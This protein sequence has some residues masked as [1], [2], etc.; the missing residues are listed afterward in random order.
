MTGPNFYNI[1]FAREVVL[2]GQSTTFITI[3][4]NDE[5]SGAISENEDIFVI[6]YPNSRTFNAYGIMS[7][8]G[9]TGAAGINVSRPSSQDNL[10]GL[11]FNN[12]ES[13]L[14]VKN[15]YEII[16][17][18]TG[19]TTVTQVNNV[20][21]SGFN[22]RINNDTFSNLSNKTLHFGNWEEPAVS[23]NWSLNGKP[24]NQFESIAYGDQAYAEFSGSFQ[25]IFDGTVL[26]VSPGLSGSGYVGRDNG[27]WCSIKHDPNLPNKSVTLRIDYAGIDNAHLKLNLIIFK[28][29]KDQINASLTPY[30]PLFVSGGA[31][32]ANNPVSYINPVYGAKSG[33]EAESISPSVDYQEV[34]FFGYKNTELRTSRTTYQNNYVSDK[35]IYDDRASYAVLKTNPKL[36]GNVKLTLDSVGNLW[37]NSIDANNELADSAYK[38]F[39]IPSTSTYA[40]DLYRF[41][42][43]GQT[44]SQIVYSLYQRDTQY[45][46]TKR[47]LAEQ[48]DNFYN[49]GVEQLNNR[50]YDENFSFFAPIWLRKTIPEF[51]IIFRLDHPLSVESY[52][53]ALN[54][55][56]FAEFFKDARIVKTFDMREKSKLGAYLRQIV[57]DPRYKERGLDV[58]FDPD[59]P[60]TWNGFSYANGTLTGKSEFLNEY[61]AK[62]RP[63]IEFEE[64]ITGGFERNGIISS[65]LINLEFLFDDEE[66]TPYSINRYFGLYVSENQLA[67]IQLEPAVLGKIA[68]QSPLPKPGVDG[69]A[70]STTSFVQTNSAGIQLPV[71]YYH[72]ESGTTNNSN[73]P[74]YQGD[75]IGKLPLPELV[76]DPL[77]IFYVKD[78][79][80]V[81]K[82]VKEIS[83]VDYGRPGS[84]DYRRV[85]QLQLFDSQEDISKY[86]GV[87]QITSQA[88]AT[89]LDKGHSQLRLH[90]SK[91]DD[92]NVFADDETIQIDFKQYNQSQIGND[93]YITQIT[94]EDDNGNRKLYV[95]RNGDV[96]NP[97]LITFQGGGFNM[98]AV[99]IPTTINIVINVPDLNGQTVFIVGAGYFILT[100]TIGNY[101]FENT[102]HPDNVP[103]G[104]DVYF[105]VNPPPNLISLTDP[106]YV[107]NIESGFDLQ[108]SIQIDGTLSIH[109]LEFNTSPNKIY[110]NNGGFQTLALGEGNVIIE[111][112]VTSSSYQQF[113]WRLI[114][115]SVGLQPGESWSYPVVD[116]DSSD[117]VT[118]FS[119]QG[120]PDQ[121]AQA[122]TKAINSFSNSPC[123]AI[124]IDS[125]IYLRSLSNGTEGNYIQ[126]TR[127]MIAG[128][129]NAYN[130]GFYREGNVNLTQEIVEKFESPA[131]PKVL[132][133]VTKN[134]G[135]VG[136]SYTYVS[137]QKTPT[138]TACLF[139]LN[140][141]YNPDNLGV[142]AVS[143]NP[144]SFFIEVGN[145]LLASPE[146]PFSIDISNITDNNLYE[147][148]FQLTTGPTA[149]KQFFIGGSDAN[150]NKAKISQNNAQRYYKNNLTTL[151]VALIAGSR[152]LS[153]INTNN[154]YIGAPVTGSGIP[155][156]TFVASI[157]SN[158]EVL[159]NNAATVSAT[160]TLTIGELDIL[161][162][163]KIKDQ[164]F[165]TQKGRY[166]EMFGWDVQGQYL[167]SLP[168]LEEPAYN[169]KNELTGYTDLGT[170]SV[171]Q[172]DDKL[173]Q[174]YQNFDRN[175]V[176]YDI[177]RPAVGIFSLFP[178]KQFDFDF[179]FSEY[180]YAPILEAFRYYFNEEIVNVNDSLILPIDENYNIEVLNKET[181]LIPTDFSI[182]LKIDGLNPITKE[183]DYLETINFTGPH[184][185]E[186][187]RSQLVLNTY[188]PFYAYDV[189]EN[190]YT[191]AD[192]DN[193]YS[194]NGAGL[195]NYTKRIISTL[196]SD[197]TLTEAKPLMYRLTLKSVGSSNVKV[198]VTKN[199][200]G[201][202]IDVKAFEGFAAI[203]DIY[204][205]D[206]AEAIRGLLNDSKYIEAFLYQL[207]RNEYDRL[208]ENF[209]KD[210]ATRS[211]VVPYIN[212]WVQEGTDAR[213]NYYR[214]STSSAFGITNLSPDYNVNF[215]EPSLLTNEFPYLDTV[216][217]DYPTES[218]EG[219]RS[220]MFAKLSDSANYKNKS[221]HE[222]L[223]SDLNDDWFT[224]FFALGYPTELDQTGNAVAK[225]RDERY[226]FFTY[227]DG[228]QKS[229]T[230]FRGAK[231]Q[232]LDINDQIIPPVEITGSSKYNNYKFATIAR[233]L[234]LTPLA[235]EKPVDI[236]VYKN[237]KFQSI[238][239][240]VTIHIQDY[241]IQSGMYD[242]L[243]LY[244]MNDHLKNYNQKQSQVSVGP[245]ASG[246]NLSIR[247]FLP[248]TS[249]VSDSYIDAAVARPRQGFFGGGYLEL[250]DTR[251]GG[252]IDGVKITNSDSLIEN[253]LTYKSVNP[254]YDFSVINEIIPSLNRY[255]N[256]NVFTLNTALKIQPSSLLTDGS[257]YKLISVEKSGSNIYH[258]DRSNANKLNDKY[259]PLQTTFS[260]AIRPLVSNTTTTGYNSTRSSQF[261]V[262]QKSS[263]LN[264]IKLE[265]FN[266]K[267]GTSAYLH[268]K[269][270]LTYAS[271]REYVNS[272]SAF[273]EYYTITENGAVAATNFKLR[274]IAPDQIIKTGVLS[275]VN[276]ED[277]PIEYIAS[278]VIGYNI[279]NTNQNEVIYRHRGLYEPKANEVLSFWVREDQKFTQHFE[280]DFLLAN[281]HFND[282]SAFSGILRNLG[283]NK[284]ADQEILKIKGDG[285]Y[286]SVYPLINEVAVA[287]KDHSV[288]NSTWD[289]NYYKKYINLSD[290]ISIN[291]IEEMQEFKSFLASKAMNIPKVQELETF[292]ETEFSFS[293]LE[294]AESI[295]VKQLSTKEISFTDVQGNTKPILTI[296]IDVKARLLRKLYEDM[297]LET[298]FDEF[299][300]LKTLGIKELDILTAIDIDRL[301]NEYLTKN[302]LPLYEISEIKLYA[303][304]KDG[305]DLVNPLLS[306]ADKIGIGYRIDKNCQVA[307]SNQLVTTIT[308][309]LDTKKS[310]GYAVSVDIKRI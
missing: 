172:L 145:T 83:E 211:K 91:F 279:V 303:L 5:E 37:L 113:S 29:D 199:D 144:L 130:L 197:G 30:A 75:V 262:S 264:T 132:A 250:G 70:Y 301:K 52:K 3:A 78:R 310:I 110:V 40:R 254:N 41:F 213:D 297:Q 259:L 85:T 121:V 257:I 42:K 134:I 305:I 106:T 178:I 118:T 123:E 291:G 214:L 195:R 128:E 137:I 73:V 267:G 76:A 23:L 232:V 294:P 287:A 36:S 289:K 58:S 176:A 1:D 147:Y 300:W 125:T 235:T 296:N 20:N 99:G 152:V 127:N 283:I 224:K 159:L 198:K 173:Q 66:A 196:N 191:P 62:D 290:N 241:R 39:Q 104:V 226:T 14:V 151:P 249:Y 182:S 32:G 163:V 142:S 231:I 77:R 260:G 69:E 131:K 280:K 240:I 309:E 215:A 112:I 119:N 256:K 33:T 200:Y 189:N 298:S 202:D 64:Y 43:N 272:D 217:K 229:Q 9:T 155:A 55:E 57:N 187:D 84:Y 238:T 82:R 265:T 4:R 100:G 38:R 270:L 47:T 184:S 141:Q 278:P 24:I 166:C 11:S 295:G 276:D 49:Y 61:Y 242:Y 251:I 164:W 248:Y 18:F 306:N 67:N 2:Q 281:T 138:G 307:I 218:L 212:K 56:L 234:P 161:N 168:Y 273:I 101:L 252:L 79:E 206:D 72:N 19:T 181:N 263:P 201:Q 288:L 115:N 102:G 53:D 116:L 194:I 158:N 8:S 65:N 282:K 26:T 284:V 190:A 225:S 34:H 221:W 286:K 299:N 140:A 107:F 28:R 111:P 261:N 96:I 148:V 203:S 146:I 277:K 93:N 143:G 170:Y 255:V 13:D 25:N 274:M 87:T 227:N 269:N 17:G 179:Y 246:T 220:Y 51:F 95:F 133:A 35:K 207:L 216:P 304:A 27:G 12:I 193:D 81:F 244:S 292:N 183:W 114:A 117:Y 236:E 223:T 171:I 135:I 237:D 233:I 219:S 177:Y 169:V 149:V 243:F 293:V 22:I 188:Y 230:L 156:N 129:S 10:S 302:I 126:L 174:F 120:T 186:E 253:I 139:R 68:G 258:V 154:I 208:R 192:R 271:I 60:T 285:A 122:L 16:S 209:N 185:G 80:D 160:E 266:I 162:T 210:Y 71:S 308:K 222:L 150:R 45:Q 245:F 31:T 86:A 205:L 204:S 167:Y 89:L 105:Y 74:A 136:D 88:P 94:P 109:I 247:E 97:E 153:N 54:P 15:G 44:P 6:V 175:I 108:N 7:A 228:I 103:P 165:Q 275:Y 48:Y 157:T 63:I 268:I 92:G 180:S 239:M 50:Y 98:P 90:L 46:N 21:N 59:L 124:A